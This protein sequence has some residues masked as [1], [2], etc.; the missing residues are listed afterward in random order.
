[1]AE[2]ATEA[3][4]AAALTRGPRGLRTLL[5]FALRSERAAQLHPRR[6][7]RLD[8]LVHDASA[9]R[10]DS[11]AGAYVYV[12]RLP[13]LRSTLAPLPPDPS[14]EEITLLLDALPLL[15]PAE[16]VVRSCVADAVTTARYWQGMAGEDVL[17]STPPI[18]RALERVAA[19]LARSSVV[20]S[21]FADAAPDHQQ[22][23]TWDDEERSAMHDGLGYEAKA[24]RDLLEQ[25]AEWRADVRAG[26]TSTW[27]THP[28]FRLHGTAGVFHD[29]VPIHL[30]LVE[31]DSGWD[32]AHAQPLESTRGRSILEIRSEKDWTDL[33]RDH[34]VEPLQDRRG[35]WHA[36]TGAD[37]PWVMPNWASIARTVDGVHLSI[38]AYLDLAGRPLEVPGIPASGARWSGRGSA[39][40]ALSVVAGWHP[41]MTYW[42]HEPP[43]AAGDAV[44]WHRVDDDQAPGDLSWVRG[45]ET[46]R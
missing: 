25:G 27:W 31:D 14:L 18:S 29:G 40:P 1:V 42:L 21:W 28:H 7:G 5:E 24:L 22:R 11:I 2:A 32:R 44:P 8:R 26:G 36:C 19:H 35:N 39:R 33:C 45:E 30:W 37:G 20:R 15:D 38:G 6:I 10:D 13:V 41:D 12:R 34:P 17:A 4:V 16:D 46:A 3:E 43:A 9:R 23:I